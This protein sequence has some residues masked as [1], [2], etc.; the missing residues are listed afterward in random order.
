MIDKSAVRAAGKEQFRD[1]EDGGGG[2]GKGAENGQDLALK[3]AFGCPCG[4]ARNLTGN[5]IVGTYPDIGN[6]QPASS[7]PFL[8]FR[9]PLLGPLRIGRCPFSTGFR[10]GDAAKRLSPQEGMPLLAG[11]KLPFPWPR[12]RGFDNPRRVWIQEK[13]YGMNAAVG[14]L[15]LE[16]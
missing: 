4:G 2:S 12:D 10:E 15:T 1:F 11:R 13:L 3:I 14:R 16:V 5:G 9:M 7:E 6:G 8:A